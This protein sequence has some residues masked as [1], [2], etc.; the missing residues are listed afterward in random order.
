V[1]ISTTASAKTP[2]LADGVSDAYWPGF[3]ALRAIAMLLGIMLHSTLAY[4]SKPL[5]GVVWLVT[6]SSSPICDVLFWWVHAWR[7]PLFFFLSGFFAKLSMDRHGPAGFA[8]RRVKRLVIP[9]FVAVYTIGPA[10][11]LVFAVGW[12]LTGQC[13][14]A[15]MLPHVPF[16][17]HIQAQAFG[18]VHLWF[19][20]DLIIMSIVYL[21][22]SVA[23]GAESQA[24]DSVKAERL[25]RWWMPM[26]FAVPTGLLLWSDPS[27]I[28][29]INNT[30]LV[31]P[32]RLLY[33][34]VYFTGGI[35]AFQ[36]R[37]WFRS[38]TRF[39]PLHLVL[40]LPCVALLMFLQNGQV[41]DTQSL[42]GRLGLGCT[43]A[44]VAWLTVYGLLGVF[45]RYLNSEPPT[46][47]YVADSSYWMYLIH[48]PV[49]AA[50]QVVLSFVE[51]PSFLKFTLVGVTTT[52]V[53]LLSY[54]VL[55]RDTII[56]RYLHGPRTRAVGDSTASE[57]SSTSRLTPPFS[58]A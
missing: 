32:S 8:R 56:G 17:A 38:T 37:T 25:A 44:M 43:V 5:D 28:V 36:N 20:Q 15:Q 34:S 31:D 3:A 4:V 26:I 53:G 1:T 50:L 45:L 11:Y 51:L 57:A 41:V 48:L 49:V 47:R 58:S 55:V 42:L 52:V 27:P 13:T 10:L 21:V 12:Y 14:S 40:S 9:Y 18:P 29:A 6:E 7:I 23:L 54:R 24:E 16:P 39:A 2:M 33:F 22:L 19:L 46:I 35:M 30:F